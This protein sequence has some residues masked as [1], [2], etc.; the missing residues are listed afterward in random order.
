MR[1]TTESD[2]FSGYFQINTWC[3]LNDSFTPFRGLSIFVRQTL[4]R[5]GT[6]ALALLFLSACTALVTPNYTRSVTELR[7]GQYQLDTDHAYVHFRIEHL[8]LSTIVGRFNKADASLDFDPQA[9]A[10]LELEGFVDVEAIDLNNRDL[11]KRLRG[12]DWFDTD[13]FPQATF[14]TNTVTPGVDGNFI[15]E[16]DF[17]LR[18]VSKPL[19]LEARFKGG[20]D[21]LLTGKYTLGFAATGSFLRSDFGIDSLRGLVADEV[22]IEINAEFQKSD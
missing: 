13:R 20:A 10:E 16:G 11:E 5:A 18:G 9:L 7:Q 6:S 21:N 17:T 1:R 12:R 19:V 8:G 3:K 2:R 22:F 15:I 4:L 14:S